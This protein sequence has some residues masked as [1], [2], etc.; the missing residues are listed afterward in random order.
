MAE[1]EQPGKEPRLPDDEEELKRKAAERP[2]PSPGR[3]GNL[4]DEAPGPG[5]PVTFPPRGE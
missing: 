2:A 1:H 5:R 3:M 4:P